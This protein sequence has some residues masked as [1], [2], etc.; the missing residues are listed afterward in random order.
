MR[1]KFNKIKLNSIQTL[2]V[3]DFGD[4]PDIIFDICDKIDNSLIK[5]Y[6]KIICLA[7][8]EH[9]YNPFQAV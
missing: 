9:V 2:N 6:D 8:L 4:Y 1:D 7:I 3:N 5:K